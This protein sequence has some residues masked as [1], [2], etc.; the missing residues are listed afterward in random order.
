MR[1]LIVDD[2]K[3]IPLLFRQRFRKEL[4]AGQI[5]LEF[6]FSAEEALQHMAG[7]GGAEVVLILSDINMPGM[8]GLDLLKVL[9]QRFPAPKVLIIT[10][11][12]TKEKYDTAMKYKA[13]GFMTKPVDFEALRRHIFGAD[14]D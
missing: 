9:K 7:P 10:A 14:S 8:N 4:R 5:E 12:D 11:Y 6:A 2:E 3:D 13:D 1:I